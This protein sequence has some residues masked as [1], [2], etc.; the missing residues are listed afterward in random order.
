MAACCEGVWGTMIASL[1]QR[2][3]YEDA[4]LE[5]RPVSLWPGSSGDIAYDVMGANDG[6]VGTAVEV[7]P[8]IADRES[9]DLTA[10]SEVTV[11]HSTTF[12]FTSACTYAI[13]C[14]L[15]A[16]PTGDGVL[17]GRPVSLSPTE[18]PFRVSFTATSLYAGF[19]N[20][21]NYSALISPSFSDYLGIW[22]LITGTYDRS[23]A[24]RL[25][26]YV[27][28]SL[29]ANSAAAD[30]DLAVRAT[31]LII[32]AEVGRRYINADLGYAAIW[33]RALSADEVRHLYLAGINGA[34]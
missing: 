11:P 2:L 20:G 12:D 14:R 23:A 9:W 16:A 13:W 15:H 26:L 28:E 29:A 7:G 33:D 5:T 31:D 18:V 32:G 8:M 24:S 22:R 17:I 25:K 34:I 4:V 30:T 19:F 1:T 3:K 10:D 6:A 21:G 27:D